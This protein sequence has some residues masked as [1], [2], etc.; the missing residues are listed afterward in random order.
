VG[1]VRGSILVRIWIGRGEGGDG[2]GGSG[3]IDH[4]S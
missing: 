4:T 1:G 2:G 3:V